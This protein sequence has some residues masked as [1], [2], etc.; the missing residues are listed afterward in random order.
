MQT[1]RLRH[2][3]TTD[4]QI[5]LTLPPDFPAGVVDFVV[6]SMEVPEPADGA[7]DQRQRSDLRSLFELLD[8]LPPAGRTREDIY[9]QIQEQR[10]S[11]EQ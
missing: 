9:R 11:W 8:T 5:N 4:C 7:V 10:D 2:T 6:R 3:V 1:L